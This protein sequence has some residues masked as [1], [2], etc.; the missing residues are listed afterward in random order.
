MHRDCWEENS[1]GST[2][3][4]LG[5]FFI[6]IN[7]LPLVQTCSLISARTLPCWSSVTFDDSLH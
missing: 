1:D 5:A 3:Q 2:V 6:V 4:A 7:T